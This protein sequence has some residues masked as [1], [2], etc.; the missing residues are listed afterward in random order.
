MAG[1]PDGAPATRPV[2]A[3]SLSAG[4][5]P[6]PREADHD[7]DHEETGMTDNSPEAATR[8]TQS[9]SGPLGA[10]L[11]LA[12]A[13]IVLGN[14]NVGQGEQ[15][16]LWP[17]IVTGVVCIALALGL[18]LL[19][20]TR[21]AGSARACLVLGIL[22]VVALVAFWS[23]VPLVLAGAAWAVRAGRSGGDRPVLVGTVLAALAAAAAVVATL[24][25]VLG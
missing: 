15:G 10:G 9:I 5:E 11:V 12:L 24:V 7:H 16:G 8:A 1:A 19:V 20:S 21:W 13:V 6:R 25:D 23:G 4:P 22:A 18:G 2:G 17:G 14:T 3:M